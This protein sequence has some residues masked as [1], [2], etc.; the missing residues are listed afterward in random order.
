MSKNKRPKRL[1]IRP[2]ARLLTMLGDQLIKNVQVALVELIKNAYDADAKTAKISFVGFGDDWKKSSS[3]AIII[4]DDGVGMDEEIVTRAWLNPATPNKKRANASERRTENGRIMQGEK[5]IGRFAMLKLGNKITLVTR[6]KCSVSEIV[7]SLDFSDYD[8]EFTQKGGVPNVPFLD[9]LR[10]KFQQ[11]PPEIFKGHSHGTRLIIE[12]VKGIWTSHEIEEVSRDTLRLQPI[13]SIVSEKKESQQED[14]KVT[15][16]KDKEEIFGKTSDIE[17]LKDLLNGNSAVLKIT[18]GCYDAK[19]KVFSFILNGKS[20]EL[21]LIDSRLQ[22]LKI[23]RDHFQPN[24]FFERSPDCGSFRFRFYIFDLAASPE[25][26]HKLDKDAIGIIK[27]HRIYLYR[28][29]IRVYPY[30]NSDDDWLE[31]DI[32]RGTSKASAF[33]SNDQVVGSVDISHEGNPGLKDKT[34]REGLIEEGNAVGDFKALL[35]SFL[36]Y[37]RQN[38]YDKYRLEVQRRREQKLIAEN[39]VEENAATLLNYVQSKGDEKAVALVRKVQTAAKAQQQIY[40]QRMELTE[41]LAGV[42]L[43]VETSSHDLM[44]VMGRAYD[45]FD[46]LTNGASRRGGKCEKCVEELQKI[47]GM[48]GFIENRMKSLQSLFA[49]AK[50]RPSPISVKE[51]LEKV[52]DIY[53]SVFEETKIKVDIESISVPLS[54]RSTDAVLLQ[55]FIN[56]FDNSLYWLRDEKS[57]NRSVWVQIDGATKRLIYADSGPG[58]PAENQPFVFEPFFSTKQAGRG[59][60]LYIAKQLLDR[61]GFSLE[62]AE[63]KADRLLKGVN[64]VVDFNAKE[65]EK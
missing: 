51:V 40:K 21:P 34:S 27:Q 33:P 12:N 24:T 17:K 43:A 30:G 35:Q 39:R 19:N 61:Q 64:F 2:Y 25:S 31:I 11:R 4:E 13:F 26:K 45:A 53:A 55:L 16:F 6:A 29:G 63:T 41:D 44:L 52:R 9:Q 8:E 54:V 59:L 32:L 60:G 50:Q 42:G 47:R 18:E 48:L 22:A 20:R 23:F 14:F 1:P 10:V 57:S 7:V 38:E 3:A 46:R 58:I 65:E 62:F 5:G 28:D 56:L 37:I 36:A 15:F 49:S